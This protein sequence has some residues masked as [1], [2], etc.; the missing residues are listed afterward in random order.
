MTA[1]WPTHIT[2]PVQRWE[3]SEKALIS[4]SSGS[5]AALRWKSVAE[6]LSGFRKMILPRKPVLCVF[7][8][9]E[10]GMWWLKDPLCHLPAG[11][12]ASLSLSS[13]LY[14]CKRW[15]LLHRVTVL[16]EIG[17]CGAWHGVWCIV[18]T[19]S[20]ELWVC[21]KGAGQQRE[22]QQRAQHHMLQSTVLWECPLT[23][24]WAGHQSSAPAGLCTPFH[25]SICHF[26]LEFVI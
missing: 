20:W 5:I 9:D 25:D 23:Q 15:C 14:K 12:L 6:S 18:S 3:D 8:I 7:Q 11:G 4:I 16:N 26:K 24:L 2:F 10:Q 17:L 21:G 1:S 19:H 22:E 13:L